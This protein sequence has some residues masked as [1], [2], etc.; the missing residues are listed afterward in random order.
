M[1]CLRDRLFLFSLF[2]MTHP[3]H[4]LYFYIFRSML[5]CSHSIPEQ[6]Q[7]VLSIYTCGHTCIFPNSVLFQVMFQIIAMK[8]FK[9]EP[10]QTG[11]LLA[12]FG[13]VQMVV[14]GFVIGRV[15]A[16]YSDHSLVLLATGVSALVGLAQAF[17]QNIFHFCLIIFPMV[18]SLGLFN[19]TMD[20]MLTNTVPSSDTG[21]IIGL[22]ASVN[23]LLRTI[24]PTIGGFL[25]E[26]YNV[27][28]FG[29]LQFAVNSI[30]VVYLLQYGLKKQES[31][32]KAL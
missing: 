3:I 22:C 31:K 12:Y 16:R 26:M 14:Q 30:V 10:A 1:I 28:S 2:D 21:T 6:F 18:F 8:F 7:K 19:T 23:A 17:M 32:D 25:Y 20:S 15:T 24:A 11:Y 13:I 9:L 27:P 4:C 5:K 29:L